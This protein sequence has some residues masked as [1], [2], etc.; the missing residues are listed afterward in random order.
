[1]RLSFCII[2][3]DEEENLPRCLSSVQG[4]VD[5]MIVLDTGSS[6]RTIEIA[7]SFGAQVH[8]FKW[9]NDF[10]AARNESLKYV[11]G[12]WVLVLDADEVLVPEIVPILK[13]AI[14][15]PDYL[16]FNL[17]RQ[18][19][20][21]AQSPYSL[22]SRLFRRHPEIWFTRPYHAMI[23]DQVMKLLER[24]RQWKIG[25]I[26]EVAILHEGYQAD[27]IAGRDKMSKA[28]STMEGFLAT[29]PNDPYVCSKLGALYV[30]IGETARGIELLERGLSTVQDV[31][32]KYELHYHL[33][34]V[35]SEVDI[36]KAAQHY[37]EAIQQPILSKLKLGAI[38]NLGSLLKD[39]G[40]LQNAQVLYQQALKIDPNFAI[41]HC[42]L[43]ATLK[44]MGQFT[45]AIEHYK[46]AI[47]LNPNYAE[48]Y[49][50]LGVVL[51]RLGQVPESLEAFKTAI[52][53]HQQQNPTEAQRLQQGLK[54]MGL[55]TN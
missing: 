28:R 35:Y 49:Q 15:Q 40:D 3:K 30:Q 12:D 37:Q 8:T 31:S 43:G 9:C 26:P 11:Q 24:E 29:H 50:N 7:K 27:M 10:S 32:T 55:L 25:A 16:V 46:S 48:A 45:T 17:V 20:G 4:F 34:S 47:A 14:A 13:S 5:E 36:E 22:I 54:E 23:D 1:M 52:E 21:A 6:D 33:G 2:V 41:A 51:L 19:I 38:N 44:A 39:C 42:N 18:E 53:L